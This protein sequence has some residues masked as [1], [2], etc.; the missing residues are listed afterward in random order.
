[1]LKSRS[2]WIILAFTAVVWV[3]V[4]M[5]EHADYP[6]EVRVEWTGYDTARYVVTYA[7]TVLPVTI[8]SNCFNAI[9]RHRAV[10]HRTYSIAI[11]GDTTIRVSNALLDG[12]LQ[13][14]DF[15]GC[16]GISAS[17]DELQFRLSERQRKAFVPELSGVE[18]HFAE[19]YGLSGTPRLEPDTVWLYGDSASLSKVSRVATQP[20][21]IYGICDSGYCPLLIDTAWHRYSNLRCSH[22]TLRL[23]IPV[24]RYVEKRVSVPVVFRCC[25]QQVRVRLYP[26]RV[27]VSLWVPR[28]GYAELYDD[29]VEAMVEYDPAAPE[30]VLPVRITRFPSFARVKTVEPS[31]LQYVIIK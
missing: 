1:M 18:F 15:T 17:V 16:H 25:D 29:M 28:S 11:Q 7:D 24:E 6:L 22:D 12:L 2:F 19:Q 23:F 13:Q 30:Q 10:R 14:M 8:N 27:M 3:L 21:H 4:T 31:T 20:S 26:E 5:S 9:A